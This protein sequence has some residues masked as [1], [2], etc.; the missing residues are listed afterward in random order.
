[1]LPSRF[2][3]LDLDATPRK[4]EMAP[5]LGELVSMSPH[6]SL[7]GFTWRE[8]TPPACL[9]AGHTS[10]PS[11]LSLIQVDSSLLH[12]A[13]NTTTCYDH[14]PYVTSALNRRQFEST[15]MRPCN[16]SDRMLSYPAVDRPVIGSMLPSLASH[17]GGASLHL[18]ESQIWTGVGRVPSHRHQHG[19]VTPRPRQ[20][21]VL[22]PHWFGA[23]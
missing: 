12:F 11:L 10:Q 23:T 1:M 3:P 17:L 8:E 9:L 14:C 22:P 20:V 15:N 7:A 16:V 19:V 2:V 21:D 13:E 18:R 6:G 5:T 4:W